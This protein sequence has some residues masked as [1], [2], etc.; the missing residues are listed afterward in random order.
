MY[1]KRKATPDACTVMAPLYWPGPGTVPERVTLTAPDAPGASVRLD[2]SIATVA[3]VEGFTPLASA[4]ARLTELVPLLVIEMA[5]LIGSPPAF[6]KPNERVE[7][8]AVTVALTAAPASKRP[9]PM[10]STS[11]ASPKVSVAVSCAA[12][13]TKAD[14]ICEGVKSGCACFTSAAAPA[15][16]GAEKLVPPPIPTKPL[17]L[18]RSPFASKR[19]AAVYIPPGTGKSGS[20][21]SGPKLVESVSRPLVATRSGLIIP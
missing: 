7:G 3:P 18:Y 9:A 4:T 1:G 20:F 8:S 10:D 6:R 17:A 16:R 11:T 13:L 14:L 21:G 5:L 2:L 15:T 12:E 19:C